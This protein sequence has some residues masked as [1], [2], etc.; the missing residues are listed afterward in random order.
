MSKHEKLLKRFISIPKDFTYGELKSLL[1]GFGYTEYTK[2]KTSGSRVEFINTDIN[3]SIELHR[4][5]HSG[6]ALRPITLK[7]IAQKLDEDG[8][9]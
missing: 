8:L 9:L 3:T 2:G 7:E 4:P 1:N 5:H 6:D